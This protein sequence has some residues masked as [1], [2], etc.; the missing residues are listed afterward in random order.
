MVDQVLTKSSGEAKE[1]HE[2][3][4][5]RALPM[6]DVHTYV[7]DFAATIMRSEESCRERV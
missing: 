6:F 5:S 1:N 3:G 7:A 4:L 2:A